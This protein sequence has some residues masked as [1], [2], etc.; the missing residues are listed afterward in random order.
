MRL[1]CLTALLALTATQA[2]ASSSAWRAADGVRMRLVTSGQA[3][4]DGTLRGALQ[5]DLQRGWKTYW[6]D[7]GSSGVP[8]AIDLSRSAGVTLLDIG[9]PAPVRVE[10]E[11]GSWVGYKHSIAFP[12]TFRVGADQ[13][14]QIAA[15]VFVGVCEQICI[16][17]QASF[18][19]DVGGDPDN[20][21]HAAAVDAAFAA[22]PATAEPGFG[23]TL[24]SADATRLV[25]QADAPGDPARAELFVAG[26]DGYAFGPPTRTVEGTAAIFTV[27]VLERPDTRPDGAG[28]P[29]TLTTEAGAVEGRLPY[30]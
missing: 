17:I 26:V 25:V 24:R 18:S 27:P 21:E 12:V 16:P 3:A 23:V 9:Y 1:L 28:L 5:I 20:P 4:A 15:D 10:D 19:V 2:G 22:L 14:P 13:P 30:P 29:Y 6:R 7:P 8:P 11:S